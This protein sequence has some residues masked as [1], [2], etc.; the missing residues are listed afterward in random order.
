MTPPIHDKN[1]WQQRAIAAEKRLGHERD[2]F[3]APLRAIIP[4]TYGE[5]VAQPWIPLGD[6]PNHEWDN[7]T[8][9]EN[10]AWII[11]SLRAAKEAAEQTIAELKREN[12]KLRKIIVENDRIKTLFHTNECD[13][14]ENTDDCI[15]GLS[16]CFPPKR[17]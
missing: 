10:A 16:A 1:Y 7:R 12:E 13:Q 6:L 4:Q 2:K 14:R 9:E 5:A 11:T 15:C 8:T 17:R 3:L